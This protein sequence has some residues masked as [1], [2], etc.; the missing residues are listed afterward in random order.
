MGQQIVGSD[1]QRFDP[2]SRFMGGRGPV[3]ITGTSAVVGQ[4]YAIIPEA[5][6]ATLSTLVGLAGSWSGCKLPAQGL[7]TGVGGVITSV[8]LSSGNAIGYQ[9]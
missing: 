1:G 2:D 5:D 8:T 6:G 9:L 7:W 4:F 3:R